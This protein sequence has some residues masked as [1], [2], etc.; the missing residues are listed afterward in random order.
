[1][2]RLIAAALGLG[3]ILTAIGE[4]IFWDTEIE[5]EAATYVYDQ[6]FE[7]Y[8]T[9]QGFPESYKTALRALHA[10]HPNWVFQAFQTGLDWNEVIENEMSFRRN[11]VP[12]LS[13]YPSSYKDTTINGA[14]DW[15]NNKWTVLSDPYWVQA[16]QAVV[17]YYMDPRNFLV[18]SY[19]FQFEL[20]TFNK[21]A[22]NLEGVEKI[23]EGTFMSHTL[24]DG[25][26]A[27]TENEY[28]FSD[29]YSVKNTYIYGLQP[30]TKVSQLLAG[31]TTDAGILRVTN[32]AGVVKKT[33][34]YV[35]TGDLVQVVV[36]EPGQAD[37]IV[38]S[39]PVLILGDI[40]GNGKVDSL[41]RAY[42]KGYI[43]GTLTFSE[44]QLKA[45]D[46]NQSLSVDNVDRAYLKGYV[47]GTLTINQDVKSENMTYGELFMQ[48]GEELNVSPYMLASR[49]RQEQGAGTSEL[50]SGTVPGYEG[51]YNYFNIKASGTTRA[52][53]IQNGMEEAKANGWDSRYKAIV[54]GA[55]TLCE[56]HIWK[57]QD[58][59]YLQ[60]FDVEG[61][62]YGYYWH[63]YM[64]NLLAACSEGYNVY[65]A[66]KNMGALQESFVFKIPV[67]Q[68]MPSTACPKPTQDGNPNYKLKS[69]SVQYYTISF[70]HDVYD[71]Y[72]DVPRSVKSLTVS[73]QA[74]ASTTKVT[75]TGTVTISTTTSVITV[76]TQ[77]ENGDTKEYRIHLRRT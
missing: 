12:D 13:Q 25:S 14:F 61:E 2:K 3:V 69:L 10:A 47:Y 9:A 30:Q 77:A 4:N 74:Y 17:E 62:Y 72:I 39:C 46:I 34:D 38:A 44:L 51:Y 37:K 68:N 24:V 35:G 28:I 49:V 57:G 63:Q 75:G 42:L 27:V 43:Y 40:D 36:Q 20:E 1:M 66:Y 45:A 73:A 50:I 18:E 32:D 21:E 60:K 29:I 11:L 15:V 33:S 53:I 67:Y 23:L 31:L 52:E 16:S 6:A 56:G 8:L 64:Q 48:I 76:K 58:T 70:S 54:G 19:M 65:L 26:D 5:A 22:Q 41:D 7:S 71:Y 59:L 55:T